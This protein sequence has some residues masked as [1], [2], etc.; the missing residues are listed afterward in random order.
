MN[1]EPATDLD[2]FETALL[3]QLK[4]VVGESATAAPAELAV[5][6][7]R[8]HLRHRGGWHAPSAAAAAAV[9]AVA[10]LVHGLWPTPAYAVSGRNNGEVTVRVMRLE[11]PENLERALSKHGIDADITYLPGGKQCAPGRYTAVPTHGLGLT[12]SAYQFEVTIPPGAVG[13]GDTFVLSAAVVPIP[14]QHGVH[15]WVNFDIAHGAVAP[16][17]VVDAP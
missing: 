9:V 7:G 17:R 16:C 11:G 2:S 6:A 13:K 1:Q 3:A 12:T 8:P 14:S 4:S 10:L 5:G 15:S